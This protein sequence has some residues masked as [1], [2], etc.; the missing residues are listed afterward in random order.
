M[1]YRLRIE[2]PY[3]FLGDLQKWSFFESDMVSFRE[4][5]NGEDNEQLE[6]FKG[7][8]KTFKNWLIWAKHAIFATESSREQVVRASCQNTQD[9]N[10]EKIF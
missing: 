3:L 9:T 2:N 6:M 1:K 5:W 10:F 7:K 8:M 4:V